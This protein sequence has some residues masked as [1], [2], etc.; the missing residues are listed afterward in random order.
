MKHIVVFGGLQRKE[1]GIFV[2]VGCLM[3][4]GSMTVMVT[5]LLVALDPVSSVTIKV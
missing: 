5:T 1:G 2:D 3:V 4:Y